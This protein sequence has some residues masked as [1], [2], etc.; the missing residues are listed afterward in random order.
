MTPATVLHEVVRS[1]RA[2]TLRFGL[3]ALGIVWGVAMLTF[4][5][6][7]AD[8]YEAN[9]ETQLEEIGPRAIFL[10]PGSVTKQAIGQRGSRPVELELEDLQR[11]ERLAGIESAAPHVPLGPRLMRAAGRSK[12]VWTYGV[13][14]ETPVIRNFRIQSGRLLQRDEVESGARVVVLGA[15]VARRMF[16]GGPA[17]GRV[18]HIDGLP[19][20]VIGVTV[21][22]DDQVIY[23][24]PADDEVAMI[25]FTTAERR[26]IRDDVVSQVVLMPRSRDES[27]EA[28][29]AAR[30]LLGFHHGFR[31][32]DR[33]AMGDFNLEEI[34]QLVAPLYL[35]LRL[36]LTAASVVTLLVGAVG[37]MNI[38][39][40]VVTERTREIGLRKAIGGSPRAIFVQFLAETLTVCLAAGLAGALLGWLA[41]MAFAQAVGTGSVMNAPPLLL[42]G[43]VAMVM[44]SLIGVGV[45]AGLLPAVRAARV[46]AAVSLRGA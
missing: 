41:V 27:W 5:L 21:P 40:V 32:G 31:T 36:F 44:G 12:L 25:P 1:L 29:Q 9:F 24:G 39:L 20:D 19:F 28:T 22:K 37:V 7:A 35:G 13:S 43:R 23:I 17:V 42:P 11:L 6:A 30:A 4:L 33:G 34:R 3:T 2:H 45:A 38:M 26:F 16:G 8:G 46:D 15:K 18:I 10:F 14:A